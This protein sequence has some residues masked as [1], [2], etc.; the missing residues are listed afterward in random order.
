MNW[1]IFKPA[2]TNS[3]AGGSSSSLQLMMGINVVYTR[4]TKVTQVNLIKAEVRS[5]ARLTQYPSVPQ[6][7]IF[8]LECPVWS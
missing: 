8:A 7:G 6:S 3:K 2:R 5:S 4:K 1:G